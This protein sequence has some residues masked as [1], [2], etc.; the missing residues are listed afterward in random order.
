MIKIQKEWF[1]MVKII[2]GLKGTGKTKTLI[3][4][5][6]T[7]ARADHGS[8]IC[9]EKGPKLTYDVSH[10]ARLIN[11]E[12]YSVDNYEKFLGFVNGIIAGNFDITDIFIDSITKICGNNADMQSLLTF[13]E[14]IEKS[15]KDINV[16]MT[17]SADVAD[18][19][20]EIKKYF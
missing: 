17:V 7:A 20:E 19:P 9:I 2:M 8:V 15:A 18:A 16:M 4:S 13:I 14:V 12:E 10:K 6:N 11:V 3:D 5:V 1:I